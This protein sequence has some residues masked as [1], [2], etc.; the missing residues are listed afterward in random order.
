MRMPSEMSKNQRIAVLTF[1][2]LGSVAA[3]VGG[4]SLLRWALQSMEIDVSPIVISFLQ[5]AALF[6]CYGY[7][8]R[9][10][11]GEVKRKP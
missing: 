10:I 2:A 7:F 5:I 1:I 9:R 8:A 3:I 6:L 11:L 4:F